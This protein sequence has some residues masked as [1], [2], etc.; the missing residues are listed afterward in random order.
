MVPFLMGVLVAGSAPPLARTTVGQATEAIVWQIDNLTRIGGHAVTVVG[1]PR[2]LATPDGAAVEFN[3]RTD[4]LFLDVNPLESLA[5]FTVEV[6][7]APAADGPSEQRFLHV[8]ETGGGRRALIESRMLPGARWCLDTFLLDGTSR[9]TL[10]DR[11]R[12][13]AADRWYAAALVYDG[14]E[15]A[16][17]VDG[18]RE[19]AGPVTFRPM[20]PGRTSIGVR[21]N[22]VSWFKGRI[23]T[24]RV[25][26][27][28]LPSSRMLSAG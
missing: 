4:G 10:I 28:A 3:G 25:T 14:T 7:F 24:I 5:R 27:D 19:L 18:V 16:H 17:Y 22:L 21:Q 26:P 23:R 15:M 8:E 6:V 12:T 2:V 20:G 11:D 1:T 13:H 9:L